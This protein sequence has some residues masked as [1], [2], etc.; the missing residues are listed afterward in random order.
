MESDEDP[1]TYQRTNKFTSGFQN[2]VDA[3]GVASYREVNPG[4][5]TMESW[6]YFIDGPGY[7]PSLDG[8]L[9]LI[10]F[11]S[12]HYHYIPIPLRHHVRRRWSRYPDAVIRA[13]LGDQGETADGEENSGRGKFTAS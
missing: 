11:S 8:V 5:S 3:Y 7:G 12:I 2:I 4:K 10:P 13:V 9:T 1:P 6:A